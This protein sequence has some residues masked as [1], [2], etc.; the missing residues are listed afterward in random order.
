MTSTGELKLRTRNRL[1]VPGLYK[2]VAWISRNTP[3]HRDETKSPSVCGPV[4]GL[5]YLGMQDLYL[6]FTMFD[7]QAWWTT[8]PY[9]Y[10]NLL[11]LRD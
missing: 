3:S 7:A 8:Y 6:S 11:I 1:C 4:G 9:P 5:F 2:G 10:A